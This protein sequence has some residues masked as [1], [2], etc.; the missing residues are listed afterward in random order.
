M[1]TLVVHMAT[2]PED[3]FGSVTPVELSAITM[4]AQSNDR[5][6]T[7]PS[8]SRAVSSNQQQPLGIA[9]LLVGIAL[10]SGLGVLFRFPVTALFLLPFV[11]VALAVAW[12][13]MIA[14]TVSLVIFAS[15]FM[16]QATS[17][18]VTPFTWP[19]RF[20]FFLALIGGFVLM[21]S[22]QTKEL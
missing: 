9:R 19:L 1:P 18:F 3:I 22:W 8:V 13:W 17:I 20:V 21:I 15:G 4:P 5:Q 14:R 10:A 7:E 11:G 16:V 6:L 2:I 12:R